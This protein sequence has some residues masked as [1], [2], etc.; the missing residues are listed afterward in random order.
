M[1]LLA[2]LFSLHAEAQNAVDRMVEN[3]ATVGEARFTSAI[4]RNPQTREVVKVVKTLR[5]GEV[6]HHKLRNGFLC[7]AKQHNSTTT[8][9]GKQAIVI[10]TDE[11]RGAARVYMLK[12]DE[13]TAEVTIIVN[14]KKNKKQE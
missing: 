12:Y 10:F 8:T 3:F 13:E 2:V 1:L 4:E 5:L 7:E 11:Q 6:N 14:F 9:E